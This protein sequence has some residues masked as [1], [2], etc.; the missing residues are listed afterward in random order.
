VADKRSDVQCGRSGVDTTR[1]AIEISPIECDLSEG[2]YTHK[3]DVAVTELG[4]DR[5]RRQ[6][7]IADDLCGHTLM[8]LALT[9]GL[10]D[11]CQ[12]GVGVDVYETR[13]DEPTVGVNRLCRHGISREV[14]HDFDVLA[15][16]GYAR[17]LKLIAFIE[18]DAVCNHKVEMH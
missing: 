5:K 7:A 11:C 16:N 8:Q 12:I 17:G 14:A 1:I 13:A 10:A 2:R 6:T 18:D 15:A 3:V 4:I 9:S